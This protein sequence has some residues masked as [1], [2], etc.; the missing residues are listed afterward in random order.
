MNAKSGRV[1]VG[2]GGKGAGSL[3][4][5][6][7]GKGLVRDRGVRLE[8]QEAERVLEVKDD[9]LM[10]GWE[11]VVLSEACCGCLWRRMDL[12]SGLETVMAI[13]EIAKA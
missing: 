7:R 3:R 4:T 5:R 9:V 2:Y 12:N 13:D 1:V 11:S 8:K 6:L 10:M